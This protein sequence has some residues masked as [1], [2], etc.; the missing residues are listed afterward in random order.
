MDNF[1]DF[2]KFLNSYKLSH[3]SFNFL[4]NEMFNKI[5]EALHL[6]EELDTFQNRINRISA[7]IQEEKQSR[8]N[9]LLQ[10]VTV[11]GG[12]GSVKPVFDVLSIAQK[13]LGWSDAVFYTIL[14]IILLAIGIG[15]LAFLM[16]EVLKKIKR[17]FIDNKGGS[18][19]DA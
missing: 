3:I 18:K 1:N 12:I 4:P 7:A 15:L 6:D 17:K 8:T 13:Y 16:P 19:K 2:E 14:L 11:L 5:G 9:S 10:F